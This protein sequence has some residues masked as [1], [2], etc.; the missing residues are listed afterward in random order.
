MIGG[1][2]LQTDPT[3]YADMNQLLEL[4]LS[5]MYKVLGAKLIG[6]YLYGSLVIG[7][8]DPNISDI[9]LVAALSSDIDD[10]EFG[11]LQT[12]HDDFAKKY[13]EWDDRIEVCYISVAALHAVRSSTS[14]IVNISPGEPF[15]RRESSREW[16]TD[17]YVVREKGIPLF[18]PSPKSIIESI[19]KDEFIRSVQANANAWRI[20]I[21]DMHNRKSQAYAI[22]TLCRALYTYKNG[23]QVSKK[24]AAVWAE[25]EF[26]EWSKLI[27]NA[28]L[29]R[30]AWCDENIDHNATFPETLRFVHFAISQVKKEAIRK[31]QVLVNTYL[32]EE[33]SL[34]D[35]LIAERRM[36]D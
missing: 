31:A 6:L 36:E 26:P 12:M 15:H 30:E 27:Q 17:W 4:L 16:L 7:D 25:K 22:L 19:S 14:Q 5:G 35:E 9:D 33:R 13:K 1:F 2:M 24:Q 8:F 3:P 28:L 23:E 21:H 10:K 32:P 11:A 29:W 18:G 34:S 20:W